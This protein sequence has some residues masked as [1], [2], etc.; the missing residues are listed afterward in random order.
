MAK[1]KKELTK[2]AN[3]IMNDPEFKKAIRGALTDIDTYS[4]QLQGVTGMSS[5]EA[6]RKIA[7][8]FY[9]NM[10]WAQEPEQA[11]KYLL[12]KTMTYQALQEQI[13]PEAA[14]MDVDTQIKLLDQVRK[15][16]KL[17]SDMKPKQI[18]INTQQADDDLVISFIDVE[19]DD[20]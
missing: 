4:A 8:T 7:Q 12:A 1:A 9:Q 10:K 13:N 5:E 16:V 17:V 6:K 20:E 3:E 19:V 11:A 18:S 14:I 15:T 2:S